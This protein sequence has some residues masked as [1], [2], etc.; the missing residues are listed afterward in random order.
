[1]GGVR[2]LP[3]VELFSEALGWLRAGF[4]HAQADPFVGMRL[5]VLLQQAGLDD[6]ESM[7]IQA[8]WPPDHTGAPAYFV[9]VI[10][11]MAHAIVASGAATE[12]ELAL[13]SLEQRLG[14]AIKAAGAVWT[15]P[16][17]V[18]G[19]GRRIN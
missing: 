13:D 11:A 14:E 1:M 15:T 10:R 6:V 17:V 8:Y 9:G 18:G 2:A 7:G 12:D 5:P 19:W 3:P 16:T 4:Q